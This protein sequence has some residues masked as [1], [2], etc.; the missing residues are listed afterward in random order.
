MADVIYEIAKTFLAFVIILDPFL[1]VVLFSSFTKGMKPIKKVE[2]AMLAVGV[3][4]AVL[5]AFLFIG[6]Y[7]LDLFAVDFSS[8][9]VAG[10]VVL[11]ILGIQFVMGSGFKVNNKTTT[12]VLIGTPML[13]GPGTITT[14][15]VFAEQYG[16]LVVTIGA[17]LSLLVIWLALIVSTQI[18]RF[19]GLKFM[20]IISRVMGLL[21]STL[22]IEFIKDGF[23]DILRTF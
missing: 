10:G 6:P 3:A 13:C 19:F 7:L 8:F 22:A 2:Q 21:L 9:K 1:G 11:L 14:A 16:Y 15:I 20:E 23:I 18:E 12:V 4:G 5:F 17:I